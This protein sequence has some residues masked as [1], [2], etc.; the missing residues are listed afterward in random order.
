[1]SGTKRRIAIF[2]VI[3]LA[4]LLIAACFSV[5]LAYWQGG[6]RTATATGSVGLYYKEFTDG[7]TVRSSSV[8]IA[9]GVQSRNYIC[10][11]ATGEQPDGPVYIKFETT[12]VTN[13]T[14]KF[15]FT[16]WRTPTDANG[17]PTG[18]KT[19]VSG[20]NATEMTAATLNGSFI[21]IDF[22]SGADQY[23]ALDFLVDPI[24]DAVSFTLNAIA[25]TENPMP[26]NRVTFDLNNGNGTLP[27]TQYVEDGGKVARVPD[28]ANFGKTE[29]WDWQWHE[30]TFIGWYTDKA[31]T[32]YW[33]F[34]TDTVEED[35][36]LYA[37]WQD[38]RNM[39]GYKVSVNGECSS[40]TV[41]E[42]FTSNN[43]WTEEYT[44]QISVSKDDEVRFYVNGK[45]VKT[46]TNETESVIKTEAIDSP[47]AVFT[48]VEEGNYNLYYKT[49]ATEGTVTKAALAAVVAADTVSVTYDPNGGS[50]SGA[51]S[52]VVDK[53]SKLDEPSDPTKGTNIDIFLGWYNGE[54]LWSFETDTVT[55]NITLTAKWHNAAKGSLWIRDGSDNFIEIPTP[56]ATKTTVEGT[57]TLEAGE[58]VYL[59]NT[60]DASTPRAITNGV[61]GFT[62]VSGKKYLTADK[63]GVYTLQFT[64]NGNDDYTLTVADYWSS[65]GVSL[66]AGKYVY[67]ADAA[68]GNGTFTK[69]NTVGYTESG[70]AAGLAAVLKNVAAGTQFKLVDVAADG[71]VTLG[72][73]S[74]TGISDG[75][76][77]SIVMSGYTL[78]AFDGKYAEF[79]ASH[80]TGG[81]YNGSFNNRIVNIKTAGTYRIYLNGSTLEIRP[82]TGLGSY[83]TATTSGYYAVGSFSDYEVLAANKLEASSDMEGTLA[84][85]GLNVASGDIYRLAKVE[86]SGSSINITEYI[87]FG[88]NGDEV[89]NNGDSLS[90]IYYDEWKEKASTTAFDFYRIIVD[91]ATSAPTVMYRETLTGEETALNGF[92]ATPDADGFYA[93]VPSSY[94]IASLRVNNGVDINSETI[95]SAFEYTAGKSY[96]IKSTDK[97]ESKTIVMPVA[98]EGYMVGDIASLGLTWTNFGMD[99]TS[100]VKSDAYVDNN[101][102]INNVVLGVGDNFK[103]FFTD[104]GTT[105]YQGWKSTPEAADAKSIGALGND[106]T[107]SN[108]IIVI[109][110]GIYSFKFDRNWSSNIVTYTYRPNDNS[111]TLADGTTQTFESLG[112]S[113]IYTSGGTTKKIALTLNDYYQ[114]ELYT[115]DSMSSADNYIAPGTTF[116]IYLDGM[117]VSAHIHNG[118]SF[119]DDVYRVTR[120]GDKYTI[121]A[122]RNG[123]SILAKVK[124]KFVIGVS[125]AGDAVSINFIG[126]GAATEDAITTGSA[127]A[128][129]WYVVGSFSDWSVYPSNKMTETCTGIYKATL[130]FIITEEDVFTEYKIVHVPKSGTIDDFVWYGEGGVTGDAANMTVVS[131]TFVID[132]IIVQTN[133]LSADNITGFSLRNPY[134]DESMVTRI[135]YTGGFTWGDDNSRVHYWDSKDN[136][137][138]W[139]SSGTSTGWDL[140]PIMYKIGSNY[141]YDIPA[142]SRYPQN[143]IIRPHFGWNDQSGTISLNLPSGKSSNKGY[144]YSIAYTA[145]SVNPVLIS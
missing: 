143:V 42:A 129:G 99:K 24:T 37:K 36:T 21:Q 113:I 132:E 104:T 5:S 140:D 50:M 97:V 87:A 64:Q 109:K 18:S 142:D 128:E 10:V 7:M 46:V 1:M 78:D 93:D 121:N 2:S 17:V 108:N 117:P 27:E 68:T 120:K 139:D 65:E 80:A 124:G 58:R 106:G 92:T 62:A 90:G 20:F 13:E 70:N 107:E 31:G 6:L 41:H 63:A 91:G 8:D 116:T 48:V 138:V 39:S 25:T 114:A 56:I 61:S 49:D 123:N 83:A 115:L 77:G 4:V 55:E 52:V 95:G 145:S 59:Y 141:Y 57:V 134:V 126:G 89:L 119:T 86:V 79:V 137:G 51:T 23:C 60:W 76:T 54:T 135:I 45:Q 131:T 53:D 122:E 102:E 69:L 16:L 100:A 144:S 29:D 98:N 22:G 81:A 3:V 103:F 72:K 19:A 112:N 75:A 12:N 28:L 9:W 105:A 43:G 133:A 84:T 47:N 96:R 111:I 30:Y 88:A 11:S 26:G 14:G 82:V 34:N 118:D 67:I 101:Y 127:Q 130:D 136:Q 71:T 94:T 110:P 66:T 85:S 15:R 33:N 32:D 44:G 38:L 74:L 35:I 125:T 40:M 73:V